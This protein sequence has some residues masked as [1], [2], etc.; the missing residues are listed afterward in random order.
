MYKT[1]H[2]GGV[3]PA[4]N[5]LTA[6]SGI[7]DLPVPALV[8]IPVTQHIGAPA[9][10]V[11]KK[12]DNV[13]TGQIIGQGEGFVS[14]NI[15]SSVTGTVSKIEKFI[16]SSGYNRLAVE[17]ETSD[18]E[19]VENIDLCKELIREITLPRPELLKKIQEAGIAGMGGATFPTHVKMFLP[20]G[21][22][23]DH[24]LVNGA[25]CEPYLTSDHVLMLEKGEEI[26][27]GITIAMQV[28]G[29][30]NAVIGIEK[31]KINAIGYL[32]SHA[33]KY[34][35]IS[36]QGL[37]VKYPQGSEKQLV[38]SILK[39]EV[40]SGGL[41]SDVGAVVFNVGTMFA[42][43]E[44]VQKNKPLIDR[45]VTVTGRSLRSPSNFR[46]RIGTHMA[47]LIKA[48]G[49]LPENTG[50]V[51]GG[52][53]MMGKA[54]NSLDV[55]VTKGTSGLLILEEKESR[56]K[57]IMNCIRC[58]KCVSVCPMGLEP[59]LLMILAERRFCELIE[60]CHIGDCMECGSCSYICPANR[61]L[62]DYIRLGKARLR[63]LKRKKKEN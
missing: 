18:D 8:T 4:E 54:L 29:V 50:K 61:P 51:I 40:P 42:I 47:D 6:E 14:S 35:G 33:A 60:D 26:L 43:Y 10:V 58:S 9:R 39:R 57:P 49:G 22:T 1:F 13:K 11:V 44:A 32:E 63:E 36:I 7:I 41:P 27:T 25:E 19:W 2:K 15:H 56:R 23:V 28:L 5:K 46:V 16:D 38:K 55:P 17:I 34:N 3:H 59:Y 45:I 53:P 37:K 24:L 30:T 21:K 20:Q 12:G 48:A 31:N 62:L 52:G